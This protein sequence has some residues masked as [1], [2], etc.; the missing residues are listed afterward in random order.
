MLSSL[1]LL[2][3]GI[4]NDLGPKGVPKGALG[5]HG[6]GEAGDHEDSRPRGRP[7]PD[8]AGRVAQTRSRVAVADGLLD[9]RKEARAGGGHV[10]AEGHARRG[11]N[12]P[13]SD[14]GADGCVC[15]VRRHGR[16]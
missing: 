16:L 9:S 8:L 5:A 7:A 1:L 12:W 4:S 2:A 11:R 15:L 6:N 14:R 13:A 10:V 3:L